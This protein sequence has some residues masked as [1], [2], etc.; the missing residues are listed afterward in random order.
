MGPAMVKICITYET[1]KV[2][3]IPY[4]VDH[5][6]SRMKQ[7]LTKQVHAED[8]RI[9]F[10]DFSA[11]HFLRAKTA[12][13]IASAAYDASML[14]KA[15]EEQKAKERF[16]CK[17]KYTKLR[18]EIPAFDAAVSAAIKTLRAERTKAQAEDQIA[19]V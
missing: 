4:F 11:T 8:C 6:K 18:Q 19:S 3:D 13:S 5:L 10:T 14:K 7:I 16:R 2:L 12:T 9:I 1:A 17:H 15:G